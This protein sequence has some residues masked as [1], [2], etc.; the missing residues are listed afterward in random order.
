MK[1]IAT[2]EDKSTKKTNMDSKTPS[3]D[4]AT[5]LGRYEKMFNEAFP[6]I[7]NELVTDDESNLEIS[8]VAKMLRECLNY[9]TFDGKKSR[10]KMV[11]SAVHFLRGGKPSEDDVTKAIYLGWCVEIL[12]AFL[13]V[14]DDI[15]DKSETRRGKPCWYKK[16]THSAINDTYLL[17]QCVYKIIDRHFSNEPYLIDL[18]RAFHTVTYLTG[19]GQ[20]LDIMTSDDPTLFTLDDYTTARYKAIVK[21]KTAFY[22]F[23]FP[24]K[25][26]M[27][28]AGVNDTRVL[29]EAEAILLKVGE[30]FQ[31]QDDYLDVYGNP[32]VTGKVGR[33]IEDGKCSWLVVQALDKGTPEQ[34]SVLKANY[35]KDDVDCVKVVKEVFQEMGLQGV[36]ATYEEE[37]YA[38]ICQFIREHREDFPK[39]LFLFIVKK[40]YKRVK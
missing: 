30:Y 36:F 18:Y 35:G 15:M 2:E 33:D 21:Y 1:L 13:L 23:S 32:D 7:V 24:V 22:T 14:A 4:L 9:N 29:K 37:A 26:G 25:L 38:G 39:D 3:D 10:G 40:I 28:L 16:A 5:I 6:G 34:V 11:I 17:E 20:G 31:I 27:I 8:G 12:Q 19:M